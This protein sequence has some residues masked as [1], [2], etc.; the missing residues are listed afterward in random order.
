L[1]RFDTTR[2][3]IV[4]YDFPFGDVIIPVLP[5]FDVQVKLAPSR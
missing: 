1:H 3:D 5:F 2:C 4:V